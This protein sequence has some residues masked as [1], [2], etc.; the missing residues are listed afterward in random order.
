MKKFFIKHPIITGVFVYVAVKSI[1]MD[2]AEQIKPVIVV[3]E[4]S[5]TVFA[6]NPPKKEAVK[7]KKEN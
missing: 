3:I 1:I 6:K 7:E 2:V 5:P 4:K